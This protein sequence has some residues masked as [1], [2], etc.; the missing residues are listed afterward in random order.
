[1]MLLR[2]DHTCFNH[3][4]VFTIASAYDSACTC[5]MCG[6]EEETATFLVSIVSLL[7]KVLCAGKMKHGY[8]NKP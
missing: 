5:G 6:M 1:M 3:L 7:L 2:N 4:F 8:M